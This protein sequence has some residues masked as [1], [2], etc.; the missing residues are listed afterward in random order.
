MDKEHY[1]CLCVPPP[2]TPLL[3][4][5]F[6][7]LPSP[8]AFSPPH[9]AEAPHFLSR[10]NPLLDMLS[11]LFCD[12]DKSSRSPAPKDSPG[13]F[14]DNGMNAGMINPRGCRE[15]TQ[16]CVKQGDNTLFSRASVGGAGIMVLQ[17]GFADLQ[18]LFLR[19]G[20]LHWKVSW[21]SGGGAPEE[22]SH[23]RLAQRS[24]LVWS[25]ASGCA[26]MS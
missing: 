13:V 20:C 2:F 11:S 5:Y 19:V 22:Y 9:P 15:K 1:S 4:S 8:P 14:R 17:A 21:V 12:P 24:S 10:S 7:H 6:S 18:P 26:I 25:I 23:I 3:D 16:E